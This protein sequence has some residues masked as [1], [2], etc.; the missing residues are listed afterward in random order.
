M[1][2]LLG[3]FGIRFG[4][5]GILGREVEVGECLEIIVRIWRVLSRD[6]EGVGG[7]LKRGCRWSLVEMSL[8]MGKASFFERR[9]MCLRVSF[10][11]GRR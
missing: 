6:E 4:E 5:I 11:L 3:G 9:R 10:F 1:S 8:L 7:E 2:Y